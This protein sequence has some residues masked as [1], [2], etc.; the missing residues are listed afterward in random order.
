M[1]TSKNI[2]IMKTLLGLILFLLFVAGFALMITTPP[3]VQCISEASSTPAALAPVTGYVYEVQNRIIY[4]TVY[5]RIT[6]E[7]VAVGIFGQV[8]KID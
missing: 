3:D 4:K 5:S 6:G 7:C 1:G 2:L 8:I